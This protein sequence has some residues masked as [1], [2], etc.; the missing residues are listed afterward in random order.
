MTRRVPGD[1]ASL[2]SANPPFKLSVEFTPKRHAYGKIG[3]PYCAVRCCGSIGASTTS[4]GAIE[5]ISAIGGGGV[6]RRNR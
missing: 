1:Y 2:R 6:P 3:V 5:G 4:V